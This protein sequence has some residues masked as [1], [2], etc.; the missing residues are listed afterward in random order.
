MSL[1]GI[2]LDYRGLRPLRIARLELREGESLALLGLDHGAAQ[3]LVDLVTGAVVPDSGEVDIFD[4]ATRSIPDS[5]A[6][7]R[8]LDQFGILS[9]RM[10]LLDDLTVEQN[11]T[12]PFSLDLDAL[13]VDLRS[14]VRELAAEVG[15]AA[16]EFA[17]PVGRLGP[18]Q[19]MRVQLGKAVALGPRVLLA[20][21][22]NALL[23]P[24]DVPRFATDLARIILER[25]LAAL[26][27]TADRSFANAVAERV[28]TLQP[29]TGELKS[30][31]RWRR[32]FG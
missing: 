8:E 10:V 23:P 32:W 14:R 13:S 12:I 5:D 24:E 26:V 21:H 22:P 11:L 31:A 30:S 29:A 28:F 27:L 20:E 15:I 25:R 18:S 1:R 9:E 3:V 16:D 19:R 4:K 2:Q 6:W 17:Q 7:L